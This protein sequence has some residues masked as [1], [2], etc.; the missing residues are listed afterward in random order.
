MIHSP[1]YNKMLQLELKKFERKKNN[2]IAGLFLI[3]RNKTHMNIIN[4]CGLFSTS[5][6]AGTDTIC[7]HP[8]RILPKDKHNLI[9]GFANDYLVVYLS[10]SCA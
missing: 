5:K 1:I 2:P 6:L 10:L 7:M 3:N 8:G 4:P 9:T